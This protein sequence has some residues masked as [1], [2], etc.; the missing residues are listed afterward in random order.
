[1]AGQLLAMSKLVRTVAGWEGWVGCVV[2]G[3][4]MTTYSA[5]GGMKSTAWV[6]II[7]PT[8]KMLGVFVALPIVLGAGHGIPGPPAVTPSGDYWSFWQN[9]ASGWMYLAALGPSFIVSPGLIQKTYGA[10][11]DRAVRIG[12]GLNAIALLIYAAM[13]VLLGMS[14]RALHPGLG[15]ID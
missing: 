5:A 10:R 11:D 15:R 8:G 3:I 6:N 14:A 13:P 9:G 1:L 2:G 7:P 12:V 4:V